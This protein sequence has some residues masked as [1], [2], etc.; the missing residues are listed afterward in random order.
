M[1]ICK[2]PFEVPLS[3]SSCRCRYKDAKHEH[4]TGLVYT[5]PNPSHPILSYPI[6]SH[7]FPFHPNSSHLSHFSVSCEG[8]KKKAYRYFTRQ[9]QC[10]RVSNSDRYWTSI[11]VE[12][13]FRTWSW[14]FQEGR[15]VNCFKILTLFSPLRCL[16]LASWR[17]GDLATLTI[18]VTVAV[19]DTTN[20]Y[21]TFTY[22]MP[23]CVWYGKKTHINFNFISCISINLSPDMSK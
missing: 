3:L 22:H 10:A 14:I 6:T 9:S 2:Y 13:S 12:Q 23:V 4:G 16:F 8:G 15:T 1:K 20:L 17:L 11:Y 7:P 21:Y 18:Y 5:T 19:D